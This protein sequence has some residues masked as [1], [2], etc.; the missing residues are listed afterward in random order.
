MM[1]Q[2]EY[3]Q[4]VEQSRQDAHMENMW[5]K[6]ARDIITGISNN[7]NV[8]PVRAIWELVQNARDVVIPGHRANIVFKREEDSFIFQHDGRPFTHKTIEALILQTSSK[9]TDNNAEVGQYGTGFLTTHKFGLKFRLRAPLLTSEKVE[10]YCVIPDF[11]IDRST[12]DKD[13]LR[14]QI[15][16]QW[17]ETEKWG[18][19]IEETTEKP[20]K[21]TIFRY[22]H[23][24]E[25]ERQNV[26][27]AFKDAPIMTP[28][29]MLLNPQVE[30]IA[31][32]DDVERIKIVYEM[33]EAKGQVVEEM[34][35]GILLKNTITIQPIGKEQ[36]QKTIFYIESKERTDKEPYL[37]KATV[38]LPVEE[39]KDGSLRVIRFSSD[40]PQIYIYLPLLG[41]ERW[42][43]NF[44]FHSPLFT[45]DKDSR[46]SL[47]L[48]GNGQN[49]DY[50][51][52]C[53][54]DVISLVNKLIWQ[55]I[56]RR[57]FQLKDA[58]YLVQVNFKTQ[59]SIDE[60]SDYYKG[61]QKYW[62]EKF[63]T[64]DVVKTL[65]GNSCEISKV[66]VLDE[67]LC[68]ACDTSEELLNAIYSLL[69]RAKSWVVPQKDDM[70]YWS[71]SINQWY[72]EGDNPRILH[73]DDLARSISDLNICEDD[74]GWLH[75]LCQYIVEV[76]RNDL[77]NQ[78]T[79]IPNDRLQ[80]QYRDQ[81]T[82]PV[83]MVAVVRSALD[84]MVPDVVEN[85]VH[86]LFADIANDKTFD[87]PQIK[88]S[89]KNY[90]NNHN[91]E[92]NNSRSEIMRLKK[93]DME[94]PTGVK[95]FNGKNYEE[96]IYSDAVV[97]CTLDLLKSVLPEESSSVGAKLIGSFEAFYGIT[98][99]SLDGRLDK[100]YDLDERTF[101]NS[102]IYDSLFRF[103][104]LEDKTEKA[105]WVKEMVKKVY[106]NSDSR[107][108]L[109]NYQVYPDQKGVF[110]YAEWLKK[111]PED[112]P[113][114]AL[115]IYDEIKNAGTKRSVKDELV[116]KEYNTFFQ[117][118]G[119]FDTLSHCQEIV[120]EIALKGFN[121]TG[122]EH[123]SQIVEIIKHFTANREDAEIWKRL[124][125][126]IESNKGQ[127]MFSTLEDQSKKDSLFSL[128]EIEDAHRLELIAKLAKEPKLQRIYDLGKDALKKEENDEKEIAFKKVLGEF[129]ETIL[130]K[131]LD[132]QIGSDRIKVNNEQNGQDMILYVDGEPT[133]YIEVKSRWIS[134]ESV[135]MSMQQHR[136]SIEEKIHYAL[137][138]ADMVGIPI[139]DA[140]EHRYPEFDKVK[141]RIEVLMNIGE[142]NERLQDATE[143][144]AGK[145]HVN[146]GYQVLVSQK[147]IEQNQVPFDAF[148]GELK[149]VV[150]GKV[151]A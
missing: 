102:L 68:T 16:A 139:E 5:G 60:L 30:H 111:Q 108:Y 45:C 17:K 140:K 81:L 98:A 125:P 115:E 105:D 57:V 71:K 4:Y 22:I 61:L 112:T 84:V 83:N 122:Y 134:K 58:K 144:N 26:A 3:Q 135:L 89:I 131:E 37:P 33:P 6:P 49:N 82:K 47:K 143:D 51:A 121:L 38:I 62:R 48:V 95:Q 74:L 28:Y 56:E 80:L 10:R 130:K 107:S 94:H 103:T 44:L 91:T 18:D 13:V 14:R 109:S 35:D 124:F 75:T 25:R 66:Y 24:N 119:V 76:K 67:A 34:P 117:G 88:D 69:A 54:K 12:T 21:Y 93:T 43:F 120:A 97:Q 40:I 106:D 145:V 151:K 142:L 110:K 92:Q 148:M 64:L 137:C 36:Q 101:Y 39:D 70:V 133:Y 100:I 52:E 146:S 29:V 23:E 150:I 132:Q 126:E 77:F 99:S 141:G 128:I 123:K 8:R 79:L 11:E 1:T 149:R 31:Y 59:Q 86:P 136:T 2:E 27:E 114:R 85:F 118:D 65:D 90:L 127:L 9:S 129:V 104:L 46:D 7:T 20:D 41:T 53:N 63:E 55:F 87:Y 50:Q 96:K 32:V 116:S 19:N 73:I 15:E 72:Y 42:G 78:I 113:D 147:V 138:V